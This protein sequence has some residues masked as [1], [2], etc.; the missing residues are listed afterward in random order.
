MYKTLLFSLLFILSWDLLA[1]IPFVHEKRNYVWL[2]GS[3]DL[4]SEPIFGAGKIDFNSSPPLVEM[5]PREENGGLEQNHTFMCDA[6]GNLLFYTDFE[7]IINGI[8][9]EIFENGSG[10]NAES[11]ENNSLIPQASLCL[12]LPSHTDKYLLFYK[13]LFFNTSGEPICKDISFVTENLYYAIIDTDQGL[14]VEKDVPIISDILDS[15][16][17]IATRHANGRDW[18]LIGQRCDSNSFFRIL[19]DPLG[20]HVMEDQFIGPD[21]LF[22]LSFAAFSPNGEKYVTSSAVNIEFG[23][24]IDLYDFD[25]CSGLLSNHQRIYEELQPT[26]LR[27]VSF[28]PDSKLLYANSNLT[29]WQYNLMAEDISMS[30]DTIDLYVPPDSTIFGMSPSFGHMMHAPDDKIYMSCGGGCLG[31]H[32]IHNPNEQGIACNFQQLGLELPTYNFRTTP[33][34]PYYTLGPIDGSLC[35]T[36]GIDNIMVS[37]QEPTKDIPNFTIFPNPTTETFSLKCN[38]TVK[39][40]TILKITDAMGRIVY[41]NVLDSGE[42][43][44]EIDVSRLAKG[45]YFYS[46]NIENRVVDVGKIVV[47]E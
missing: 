11:V 33:N 25:R 8:N 29:L 46:V 35:D 47:V 32:V 5:F 22:G 19:I 30:T 31:Y 1:Q 24:F 28:S 36:L 37:A 17:L 15:G 13:D 12:P 34:H 40:N 18:W 27:S 4:T 9:F 20:I 41:T 2:T 16:K 21:V 14:V 38:H 43:E 39:E 45:I 44:Y 23:S 10:L 6:S 3:E 7:K 26:F 42:M